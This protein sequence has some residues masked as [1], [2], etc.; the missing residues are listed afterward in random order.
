MKY[1]LKNIETFVYVA[2]L[3]NFAKAAETLGISRAGA[4][5]R[6]SDLE[7]VLN[8]SLIHRTTR[9]VSLTND[10][11]D[12]FKIACS[13]LNEVNKIDYFVQSRNN[14]SGALRIVIPPYFSRNH[15]VPH[16]EEF[17]EEYPNL[18]LDITLT[19]NPVNITL[20]GYDL[21]I[22]IQIPEEE[23][24]EVEKLSDNH[25]IVCASPLYIMKHNMPKTPQD[26]LKHNCIIFGENDVWEFKHK[27]TGEVV[28]LKD[29]SGNIVCNNGE[30]IKDLVLSGVGVTLKSSKDVEKELK[31]LSIVK[32]LPDYEVINKT[33]FYVVYP[34]SK[35]SSPKIKA[36]IEFFQ[37]KLRSSCLS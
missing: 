37:K 14:I 26:L 23:D 22:R 34:H 5:N 13:I 31:D 28:S 11:A 30:I 19:E 18:K 2:K 3:K 12:F 33:K 32:L 4:T 10:G 25:K 1:D 35:Y 17:L 16:L 36:F 29:M 9:E 7:K 8:A 27:V 21:Q 6:I 24:L 15:I 20:E